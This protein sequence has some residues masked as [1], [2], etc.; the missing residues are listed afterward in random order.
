MVD[1]MRGASAVLSRLI[2]GSLP[3]IPRP[4]VYRVARRYVAGVT[5]NDALATARSLAAQGLRS[6][7]ALLGEH[8]HDPAQVEATVAEY[9]RLLEALEREGL[10]GG[11]SVKP[12]HVG[13]S[14]DPGLCQA[15]L[16]RLAA[17]AA[18]RG[19]FLR[20]DMEDHGTTDAALAIHR[21]LRQRHDN[22]GIVL[23]AYLKRTLD[24]IDALPPD[25][26]V[27]LC[28]G[29]YVEPEELVV[30][31]YDAVRANYLR[32]LE[33]LLARGAWTALATHDELLIRESIELIGRSGRGENDWELQMLLGVAPRLRQ[34][35]AVE[36]RRIRV[37]V[38]YGPEWYDYSL[39]RL[40]ENPRIAMH[41]LRAMVGRS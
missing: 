25:S 2:A 37:Y 23:Q 4:I 17:E 5:M 1:T 8:L 26:S 11:V 38:P 33:R 13:L 30:G 28:K 29:I 10:E 31:G 41:V 35:L 22:V 21:H 3:W 32:A 7:T 6:T 34:R 24:D 9:V 14:I 36:G 16:E 12:T 39:R 40:R 20:I 18:R 27:R 15:S 19:R